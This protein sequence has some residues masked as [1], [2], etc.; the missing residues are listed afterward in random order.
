[1]RSRPTVAILFTC[2]SLTTSTGGQVDRGGNEQMTD[3]IR[4]LVS[5][6]SEGRSPLSAC[7][8]GEGADLSVNRNH[9]ETIEAGS[10]KRPASL[11]ALEL[12]DPHVAA[13]PGEDRPEPSVLAS[14][15]V[16]APSRN[17][18]GL[19]VGDEEPLLVV[20]V[21][22]R[23]S[24]GHEAQEGEW[25]RQERAVLG[26][27]PSRTQCIDRRTWLRLAVWREYPI[28][29]R[30]TVW[31]WW[32]HTPEG[33]V[34]RLVIRMIRHAIAVKCDNLCFIREATI[35]AMEKRGNNVLGTHEVDRVLLDV[36]SNMRSDH[37][38]RPLDRHR[39]WQASAI[40]H[41]HRLET[42]SRGTHGHT[43][44][45]LSG[46]ELQGCQRRHKRLQA[47]GLSSRP[48]PRH[49]LCSRTRSQ[50]GAECPACGDPPCE[51]ESRCA[52]RDGSPAGASAAMLGVKNM[53]SSSAA[54]RT[55][56]PNVNEAEQGHDAR[57]AMT[58]SML[59]A[60]QNSSST[61]EFARFEPR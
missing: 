49:S 61:M 36:A 34:E 10:G 35:S 59:L 8:G 4:L 21:A 48:S 1:M 56:Q 24:R 39:V 5:P 6:Q 26:H 2:P 11:D 37:L 38:A 7:G 22:V 18:V 17:F 13:R 19:P 9:V 16:K 40:A 58:Q 57:W 3:P 29:Q 41:Q 54:L 42:L 33:V 31:H 15:H 27:K 47:P 20:A 43:D 30:T 60:V 28:R 32:R 44:R 55:D 14:M 52:F 23:S 51:S 50:H 25:Q 53:H 46:S 12:V 45:R